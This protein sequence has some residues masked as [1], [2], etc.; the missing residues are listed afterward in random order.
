MPNTTLIANPIRNLDTFDAFIAQ[1]ISQ[2]HLQVA[3][4]YLK[5]ANRTQRS[6]IGHLWCLD[7]AWQHV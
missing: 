5:A 2:Y 7:D 3:E 6:L 4:G 1:R